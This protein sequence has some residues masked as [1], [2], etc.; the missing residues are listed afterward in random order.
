MKKLSKPTIKYWEYE[1]TIKK[2]ILKELIKSIHFKKHCQS[3]KQ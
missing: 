1:T 3:I 2:M